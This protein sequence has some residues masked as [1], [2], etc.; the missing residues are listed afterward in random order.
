[1]AL[2]LV[3]SAPAGRRVRVVSLSGVMAAAAMIAGM[4]HV[5]PLVYLLVGY[6]LPASLVPLQARVSRG[7]CWASTV[8]CL[9]SSGSRRSLRSAPRVVL[10]YLELAYLLCY[11]VPLAGYLWLLT[12]GFEAELGRFWT[13]V[14]LASF[15]CYGVLPWMPSRA[16]RAIEPVGT[17]SRSV[18]QACQSGGA[19]PRQRAMEHLPQRA[20]GCVAGDRHG[21]LGSHA[22]CRRRSRS[23]CREHCDRQRRRPLS[24][25]GR[26]HRR[27]RGRGVRVRYGQRR[28]LAVSSGRLTEIS[29]VFGGI[30]FCG[31]AYTTAY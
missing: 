13:T 25:R 4:P 23:G 7:G 31:R 1:M 22:D 9:G 5:M 26:C 2:A 14:L 8:G 24:L 12:G 30:S 20:Y 17:A 28:A 21:R 18:V 11:A 29:R 15:L 16:P 6:W 27:C 3:L 19:R 10:E